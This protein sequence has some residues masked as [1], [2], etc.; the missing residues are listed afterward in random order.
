MVKF[1]KWVDWRA[2]PLRKNRRVWSF[3]FNQYGCI[4]VFVDSE[5]TGG[6]PLNN[7]VMVKLEDGRVISSAPYDLEVEDSDD[8]SL[9]TAL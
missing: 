2:V 1:N 5:A 7:C 4:D 9:D 6:D 3:E 8:E